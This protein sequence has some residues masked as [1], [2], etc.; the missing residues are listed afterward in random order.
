MRTFERR[1]VVLRRAGTRRLL[2]A[3]FFDGR[4]WRLVAAFFFELWV[5][6]L[7][8]FFL[9]VFF[10]FAFVADFFLVTFFR[11]SF[12]F[13]FVFAF[14]CDLATLA[15]FFLRVV[16]FAAF[17]A[18]F[19]LTF[20]VTRFLAVAFFLLAVAF[21]LVV[22]FTVRATGRLRDAFFADFFETLFLEAAFLVG[23]RGIP[24]WLQ[25]QPAIIHRSLGGGSLWSEFFVTSVLGQLYGRPRVPGRALMFCDNGRVDPS[26]DAE[27]GGQASKARA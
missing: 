21:F 24:G 15:V 27:L 26:T 14:A 3:V 22:F 23:M 11:A 20:F 16:F 6:V 17:F 7:V 19:L 25:M 5:R 8:A 9:G 2:A 12:R 18:V 13:A 10:A 4:A 1:A